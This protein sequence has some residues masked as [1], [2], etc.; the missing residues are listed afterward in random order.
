M[1]SKKR[2]DISEIVSVSLGIGSTIP[3]LGNLP[4]TLIALTDQALY[5]AKEQGGD[6]YS[7]SANL[8]RTLLTN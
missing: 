3:T 7:V 2:S 1:T 4:N 8:S 6:R 5:A